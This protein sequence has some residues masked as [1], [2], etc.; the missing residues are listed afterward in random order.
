MSTISRTVCDICGTLLLPSG[1]E[2]PWSLETYLG[3]VQ[4]TYKRN[5]E[6]ADWDLCP[7]C[8]KRMKKYLNKHGERMDGEADG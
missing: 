4:V 2:L 7:K 1:K 8:V 6:S 5:G 3:S